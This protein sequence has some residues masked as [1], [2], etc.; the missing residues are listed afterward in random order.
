MAARL[1]KKLYDS[2]GDVF[3]AAV[4][5]DLIT[6]WENKLIIDLMKKDLIKPAIN[7]PYEFLLKRINN[8]EHIDL[9]DFLIEIKYK[10][11]QEIDNLLDKFESYEEA[12]QRLTN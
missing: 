1:I 11:K 6:E 10:T 2:F 8:S 3:L 12:K 9:M 5:H 4:Q 7:Y